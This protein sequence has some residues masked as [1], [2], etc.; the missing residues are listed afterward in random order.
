MS[1]VPALSG[2]NL[3]ESEEALGRRVLRKVAWRLIPLLALLYIFNILDRVNVG[4]AALTC[5]RI[6]R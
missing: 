6:W 2:T 3:L 1:I 4:F 5:R